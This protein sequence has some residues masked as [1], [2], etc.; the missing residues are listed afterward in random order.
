[1]LF[2][3]KFVIFLRSVISQGKVVALDPGLAQDAS[4]FIA[5]LIWQQWVSKG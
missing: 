1:M 4:I 5:V 3:A 2:T